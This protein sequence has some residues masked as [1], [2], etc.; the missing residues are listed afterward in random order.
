MVV[1]DLDCRFKSVLPPFLQPFDVSMSDLFRLL[2]APVRLGFCCL[3]RQDS[4]AQTGS[5]ADN[6]V[7]GSIYSSTID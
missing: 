1:G 4:F 5:I 2:L 7:F 6:I 3:C